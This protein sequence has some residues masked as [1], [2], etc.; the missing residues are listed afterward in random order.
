MPLIFLLA[1]LVIGVAFAGCAA[2]RTG[3][4]GKTVFPYLGT[5]EAGVIRGGLGC[6]T[7]R[8][9][10]EGDEPYRSALPRTVPPRRWALRPRAAGNR[11]CSVICDPGRLA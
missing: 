6:W 10:E 7:T 4:T 9:M 11:G 1:A 3:T 5:G 2:Y 8:T